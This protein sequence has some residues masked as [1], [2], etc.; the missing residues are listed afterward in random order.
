MS[1]TI[2]LKS[3]YEGAEVFSS[4]PLVAVRNNVISP[5]E[6]A[7]LIELAKPHI[8]RAGVVL[9]EGFKPS[10]GRT[11]S[12]HWLKYDEDDVVKS[13]GQRIADIVGLPLENAESMQI[14]HYGPEQEYRPHFDAFNL[15]LARGQKAAQWGGQ[16]LVT[17]LVYLNK[18][19]GGGAT[20]FPKLGIT[21]P[22]S[23]GRMVIFHNTTEDISGPHPLSLHAG[24]PVEAGE[25]WAFNLWFRHHDTREMF[26][27]D[28]A[29]PSVAFDATTSTVSGGVAK[30]AQAANDGA[31]APVSETP[32]PMRSDTVENVESIQGESLRVVAN[33]ADVLWQRAVK[34]LKARDNHFPAVHLSYWDSYG[35]KPQPSAPNGWS[36]PR[37]KTVERSVLNPLSDAGKVATEMSELGF[38]HRVPKTYASVQDALNEQ[39]KADDLWFIRSQFRGANDKT[40]CLPTPI[41]A[42]ATVP[43]G[44]LLQKAV[45]GLALIDQHKFT[46]RLYMVA[47]AGQLMCF[48]ESVV[49]V[50]GAAYAPNDANHASQVDNRSYRDAGSH[51]KLVLGN[52]TPH[53]ATLTKAAKVLTADMTELLDEVRQASVAGDTE[54]Q[55]FAILALDTLLTKS[56]DLKLL[57]IHTF[58]NFIT[59]A[60]IDADVH[61]PLFEDVLRV[62]AGMPSRKLVTITK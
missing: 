47:V 49:F 33:R 60:Q 22:A 10:E 42:A 18:V 59:T 44:H 28:K 54:G 15:S 38:A 17:A 30:E 16:R 1:D 13:I 2:Q 6:C 41:M 12:N 45:D 14:I 34:T 56:G 46:A 48:E 7:Y 25:K 11:G 37:F 4:E 27:R 50:H 3:E 24:M 53:A 35:N 62:M 57:R 8:K 36:G 39:P 26:D 31:T 55:A 32:I 23:P 20:Q 52:Q 21:V 43:S 61:V 40:L 5:I 19:E 58:P 51:I 29:L 9:D